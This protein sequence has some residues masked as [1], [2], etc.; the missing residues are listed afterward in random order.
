MKKAYF[1]KII[2]EWY[3]AAHRDLPWRNTQD[4]YK[5]WL[6]E[7]IL[8]QTRVLQGLPYYQKFIQNYPTVTSLAEAKEQE[9]L[10]L[11]QGLGYYTRAR[12][13]HKCAREVVNFFKGKFPPT[14]EEL[15]TLPGI[16]DYTAAAIASFAFRQPVAV[17]DGNVYRVLSRVFGIDKDIA[18]PAGKKFF[19]ELANKLIPIQDPGT[20]NQAVMEFGAMH[21]LPKNPKCETCIFRSNCF[22]YQHEQ[23]DS[24]PVKIKQQKITKRYFYYFLIRRGAKILMMRR[25]K[26]DIWNGLFDFLLHEE[27]RPVD[28]AKIF[29]KL[30]SPKREPLGAL[31]KNRIS[32]SYRHVLSHQ[33]IHAHFLEVDWPSG[34]DLPTL[35]PSATAKWFSLKQIENLPK[36]VLITRYLEDSGIL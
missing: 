35:L 25:T 5:I 26:K 3:Q 22:A 29:T 16:G 32:K 31:K 33:V 9:V 23:Q 18:S 19:S 30:F 2:V 21:C 8:Q 10:R 13:L 14:F 15:R 6:S 4:P 27:R 17:V 28:P 36:S 1:S 12:N 7:I 11:W 24:L 20:Y 34:K